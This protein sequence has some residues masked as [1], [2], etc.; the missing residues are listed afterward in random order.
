MLCWYGF[1]LVN[2]QDQMCVQQPNSKQKSATISAALFVLQGPVSGGQT[3]ISVIF[4]INSTE[5]LIGKPYEIKVCRDGM[6]NCRDTKT[7]NQPILKTQHQIRTRVITECCSGYVENDSKTGCVPIS[8]LSHCL[9][10]EWDYA[11]NIC[12]CQAGHYGKKY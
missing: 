10:G 5:V 9:F 3:I 8:T 1:Q 6:T 4:R 11:N 2:L 7:D 12:N